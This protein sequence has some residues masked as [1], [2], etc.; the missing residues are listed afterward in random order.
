MTGLR[1]IAPL[2]I[3]GVL[4]A[5]CASLPDVRAASGPSG[6]AEATPSSSTTAAMASAT[7]TAMPVSTQTPPPQ[8]SALIAGGT[9]PLQVGGNAGVPNDA[10]A[11]VMNV[12]VTNP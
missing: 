4:L 7:Q 8:A 11:V 10:S 6:E 3:T 9:L 5:A 1:R 12:T 2:L